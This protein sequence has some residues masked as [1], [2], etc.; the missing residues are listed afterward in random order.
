MI[1]IGNPLFSWCV[2]MVTASDKTLLLPQ[3]SPRYLQTWL[4]N[5]PNFSLNFPLKAPYPSRISQDPAPA[6]RRCDRAAPVSA[7]T[8][9]RKT[10]KLG[11]D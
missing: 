3:D 6:T 4:D 8:G 11:D 10:G 7:S 2:F 9:L 1:A 5:P